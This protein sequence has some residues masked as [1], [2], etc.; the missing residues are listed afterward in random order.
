M[1]DPI[2]ELGKGL[3]APT[4]ALIFAWIF[5]NKFSAE[6]GLWQ[7]R[8]EQAQ[9]AA[10]EF[11]KLYGEFFATWKL[12]NYHLKELKN[13]E[14][15]NNIRWDLLKKATVAE[16]GIEALLVKIASE[17]ELSEKEIETMGCFRQGFQQL[18]QSIRDNEP[19]DWPR[20]NC[21]EYLAFKRL[22][23]SVSRLAS[24]VDSTDRPSAL[25]AQNALEKVTSNHWETSW[26]N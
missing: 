7:K 5:G 16:A 8:R 9:T 26:T 12:W 17:R 20:S 23:S 13:T 25:T 2:I 6:W 22:A 14:I 24:T 3:V 11:Y 1:A 4:A 10:N 15:W 18:R 19:L 21:K